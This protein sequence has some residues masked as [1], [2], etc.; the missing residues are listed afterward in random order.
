MLELLTDHT[1]RTVALGAAVLG[2]LSGA[3]GTFAVLR[4]QSLLGDALAH[5]TLPGVVLAFLVTQERAT[6]VLMVGAGLAAAAAALLITA[7]VRHTRIKQDAALAVVLSVFFG[8]GTVLLTVVASD[9]GAG[10]AG[11][12]RFV[13]GQ[14]ATLVATDVQTMALLAAIAL[15]L[16]VACFKELTV[17]SF[18]PTFA[19]ALGYRV[20]RIEGLLTVLLVVAI[21]VGIQTVGVVLVSALLITPAA[22]ARHWTDR[23]GA[24]VL[25]AAVFGAV[26][27]VVGALVSARAVDLPT[28]PVIVLVATTI[29]VVSLPVR[30]LRRRA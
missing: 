7:V 22:A 12:D 4:R 29:F 25:L 28:G 10:Q 13:L 5:A 24:M 23:L 19:R 17:I 15:A 26:S 18:D 9:G 11:L 1:L 2:L 27:G 6:P 30:R 21:V 8:L 14:A 16:V 3:L 20:G